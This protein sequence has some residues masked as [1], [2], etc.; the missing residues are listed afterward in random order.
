MAWP[1]V[2]CAAGLVVGLLVAVA[3]RYGYHRDELYFLRAGADPAWG[4][5]DQPPLTPLLAH[6]V[7]LLLPGSLL[8]LRTPSALLAG[9]TVVLAALTARELGGGRAAQA[10]AAASTAAC[11]VVLV[12]GHLLSTTTADLAL[13]ALLV[14]LV[15]RVLGGGS[16]RLLLVAGLVLG[17]GLQNKQ[18]I[19]FVAVALGLGILLAG[20]RPLLRRP[21]P[22]AGAA[23]ALLLWA[24]NILWQA[25][26]GWPQLQMAG[27]IRDD[28]AMGGREAFLPMQLVMLGPALAPL[29]AAGLTSLLRARRLRAYRS[30]GVAAVVLVGVHLALGGKPY[31][32]AGVFAA[33]LAAGG[34]SAEAW[35]ARARGLQRRRRGRLLGGAVAVTGV[36]GALLLLPVVPSAGPG[37]RPRCPPT[38]ASR[39]GGRDWRGP[40]RR[41]G[42]A[43]RPGGRPAAVLLTANYGEAGA[44]DRYGRAHGL[45]RAFSPHV[46]YATW[47]PPSSA[48]PVVLVGFRDASFVARH[49]AGCVMAARVDNGVGV[50]NEEQG[51][52][53]HLCRATARPWAE[54][55]P[56]LAH[57]G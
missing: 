47:G 42:R 10:V 43:S 16:P 13:S 2:L 8:A 56:Q 3:A 7:D 52:P 55:W 6:G 32:T 46:G 11:S 27:A 30:I 29:A 38:R 41:C 19:G 40:W 51:A 15:A 5:P 12:V 34:V 39:S 31:Y 28:A 26:H 57:L 14:L 37:C 22:W 1:P 17:V 44:L 21:E 25:H 49:F 20:P 24:P 35:L 36:V 23:L 4:Y 54:L 50:D 53:V 48:G 45:P 18:L 33:V 9:L